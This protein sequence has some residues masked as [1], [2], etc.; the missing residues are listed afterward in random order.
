MGEEVKLTSNVEELLKQYESGELDLRT[1]IGEVYSAG[2]RDES[3]KLNDEDYKK[4]NA[5]KKEVE[6]RIAAKQGRDKPYYGA[7]GGAYVWTQCFTSLGGILKVRNDLTGE[8]LD[9][10]NYEDW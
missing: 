8:E 5:W 4:F 2:M 1:L 6:S 9:F 3:I 10:T 7:I